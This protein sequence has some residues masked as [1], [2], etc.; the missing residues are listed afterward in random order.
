MSARSGS[1]CSASFVMPQL[2]ICVVRG[3]LT[4]CWVCHDEE[5]HDPLWA[6]NVLSA[7]YGILDLWSK[8]K[9][10]TGATL[11]HPRISN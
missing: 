9:L 10:T 7:P 5:R 1:G 4:V 2:S 11:T 6:L 3:T 8:L